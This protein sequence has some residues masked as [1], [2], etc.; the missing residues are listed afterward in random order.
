MLKIV[1]VTSLEDKYLNQDSK[2]I[3]VDDWNKKK[4]L[5]NDYKCYKSY[6][7]AILEK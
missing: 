7:I 6:Q 1:L 4:P 5:Q 3:Q 2:K